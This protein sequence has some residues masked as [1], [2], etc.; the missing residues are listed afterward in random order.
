MT[1]EIATRPVPWWDNT[2]TWTQQ[3]GTTLRLEDMTWAHRKHALNFLDVRRRQV[4][5]TIRNRQS[6]SLV[7]ADNLGELAEWA[8]EGE[9]DRLESAADREII[10]ETPL[11]R[12]LTALQEGDLGTAATGAWWMNAYTWTTLH[13]EEIPVED[14]SAPH[15]WL[16]ARF[17]QR[18]EVARQIRG[19][20]HISLAVAVDRTPLMRRLRELGAG[21]PSR[22]WEDA[23]SW[24]SRHWS[25]PLEQMTWVHR[26]N[27]IAHLLKPRVVETIVGGQVPAAV[28]PVDTIAIVEA[29]PLMRRLRELQAH[30]A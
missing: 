1:T 9:L 11:V 23:S 20:R 13:G 7:F 14:L 26:R 17:L 27:V 21:D 8:I 6:M 25:I 4:A 24:K 22:F 29:T 3:D 19:S 15:R 16:I 2:R 5:D 30:P 10:A 18:A 28:A 12:R